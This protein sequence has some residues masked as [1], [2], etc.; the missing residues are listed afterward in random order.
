MKKSIKKASRAKPAAVKSPVTAVMHQYILRLFVA[1]ATD[2]SHHAI[3]RVRE[4]CETLLKGRV[5]PEVIDIYQ[6]PALARENQIVATP[7]LIIALPVPLRRFIG[8]L[9]NVADLFSVLDM[10]ENSRISLKEMPSSD[11][12]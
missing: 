7:T 10:G 8:N 3:L 6:Q 12:T 9:T 1:G 4:L 5:K 11:L 2:R